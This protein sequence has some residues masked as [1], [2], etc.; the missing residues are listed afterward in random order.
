MFIFLLIWILS[1]LFRLFLKQFLPPLPLLDFFLFSLSE[2][3]FFFFLSSKAFLP[4]YL[5]L[6]FFYHFPFCLNPSCHS[7]NL[8]L[9]VPLHILI[10]DS[11]HFL[12]LFFPFSYQAAYFLYLPQFFRSAFLAFLFLVYLS[13]FLLPLPFFFLPLSSFSYLSSPLF[14]LFSHLSFP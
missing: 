7:Q 6:F 5:L 11:F 13:A 10:Q 3:L 14:S 9:H 4:F 1:L 8:Y 12:F 2:T